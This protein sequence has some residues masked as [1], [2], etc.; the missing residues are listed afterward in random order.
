MSECGL[1]DIRRDAV[2]TDELPEFDWRW[3]IFIL[4]ELNS[5]LRVSIVGECFIEIDKLLPGNYD[6]VTCI[7]VLRCPFDSDISFKRSRKPY[8]LPC[9]SL[10]SVAVICLRWLHLGL[11]WWE[12]AF[13]STSGRLCGFNLLGLES[14]LQVGHS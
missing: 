12:V 8:L 14:L 7:F 6:S 10:F 11:N 4:K 9:I 3:A 5:D 2:G 1:G 13:E